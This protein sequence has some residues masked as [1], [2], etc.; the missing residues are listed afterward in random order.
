M[1]GGAW[2]FRPARK[3]LPI[4]WEATHGGWVVIGPAEPDA[5]GKTCDIVR[6][7][8][9]VTRTRR[10]ARLL[11]GDS[12]GCPVCRSPK[13]TRQ[14]AAKRPPLTAE[15]RAARKRA[16]DRAAYVAAR[17]AGVCH[18]CGDPSPLAWCRACQSARKA[19]RAA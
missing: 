15:E 16:S 14:S 19:K 8:C 12:L 18:R 6:C 4:G 2:G 5:Q 11:S 10:S 3:H 13:K 17:E 9:G 1:S 7:G